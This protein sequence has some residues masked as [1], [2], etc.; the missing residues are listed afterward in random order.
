MK[1]EIEFL[2]QE[3]EELK[4]LHVVWANLRKLKAECEEWTWSIA[5][6]R[7]C[8]DDGHEELYKPLSIQ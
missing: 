4:S 1:R 2:N 5:D 3:I 7:C 6:G 8:N